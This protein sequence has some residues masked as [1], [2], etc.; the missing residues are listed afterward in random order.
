MSHSE[1]FASHVSGSTGLRVSNVTADTQRQWT[2][3]EIA[4]VWFWL[5]TPG[6][7]LLSSGSAPILSETEAKSFI[8][9]APLTTPCYYPRL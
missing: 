6:F 5:Q 3:T 8:D 1:E 9:S 2:K 7:L 4:T